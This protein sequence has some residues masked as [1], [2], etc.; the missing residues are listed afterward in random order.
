M[1][2]GLLVLL[3]GCEN[4]EASKARAEQELLHENA[5]KYRSRCVEAIERYRARYAPNSRTVPRSLHGVSCGNAALAEYALTSEA[6]RTVE[7]S[8]IEVNPSRLS[9]YTIRIEGK[10]G[11][12]YTYVDRGIAAATAEQAGTFAAPGDVATAEPEPDDGSVTP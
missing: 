5:V 3:V 1:L 7:S 2:M 12:T 8:V 9:G 10:N 4:R 6:G 11:K